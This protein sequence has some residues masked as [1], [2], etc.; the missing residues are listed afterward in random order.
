MSCF[1]FFCLSLAGRH[2][3]QNNTKFQPTNT[4]TAPP[5]PTHSCCLFQPGYVTEKLTDR[6]VRG[7]IPVYLGAPDVMRITTRKSYVVWV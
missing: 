6:I 2:S 4:N 5:A 7:P 1:V 3:P